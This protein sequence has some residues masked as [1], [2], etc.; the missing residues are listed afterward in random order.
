MIVV[1]TVMSL[2]LQQIGLPIE[3]ILGIF[4]SIQKMVHH[5]RRGYGDP[6]LCMVETISL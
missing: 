5:I 4:D 6:Q 3:F 2:A 1:H